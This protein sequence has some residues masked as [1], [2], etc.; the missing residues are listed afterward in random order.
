MVLRLPEYHGFGL[1][2]G[3]AVLREVAAGGDEQV[4]V[5]WRRIEQRLVQLQAERYRITDELQ[6]VVSREHIAARGERAR[7]HADRFPLHQRATGHGCDEAGENGQAGQ[8]RQSA[9]KRRHAELEIVQRPRLIPS[10]SA[11]SAR[12]S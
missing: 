12:E 10:L 9:G 4:L 5:F 7:D 1:E 11:D 2:V 8:G 6:V 3:D